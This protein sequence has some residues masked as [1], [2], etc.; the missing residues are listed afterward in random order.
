MKK[1]FLV[2]CM[3]LVLGGCAVGNT[4]RYDLGD[5]EFVLDTEKSVAVA[6]VDLR[7][8]VLSDEKPPAFVGLQRGG[9]GN[10]FDVMTDSGHGLAEDLTTSIVSSLAAAGVQAVGVP[11]PQKSTEAEA[12]QLLAA[13][14]AD[15]CTLLMVRE[16]RADTYFN[17]GLDYD[18][19]LAVL[20]PEGVELAKTT[21][22]GHDNLG[23]SMVP[24]DARVYAE[25]AVRSKL[26]A[27]FGDP[28][29]K[30]ALK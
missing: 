10:P 2:A 5:A 27:I 13:V 20:T 25:T 3:T 11:V 23:S 21:L 9:Y 17:T 24:A 6:V 14:S 29:I 12:R 7:T 8:Y 15:R 18:I 16:W 22:Q 1:L 30:G 19:T 4:H 28:E 26:E